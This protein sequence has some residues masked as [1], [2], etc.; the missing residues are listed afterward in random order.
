MS[1]ITSTTSSDTS[2]LSNASISMNTILAIERPAYINISGSSVLQHIIYR[3]IESND[4]DI[5]ISLEHEEFNFKEVVNYIKKLY[6]VNGD[7]CTNVIISNV[8]HGVSNAVRKY[9]SNEM[10]EADIDENVIH[11]EFDNNYLDLTS[12]ILDVNKI[13][14]SIGEDDFVDIDL[15]YIS[16]NIE[17]HLLN[18]YD[19]NVVRNYI[20]CDNVIVQINNDEDIKSDIAL[21]DFNI[22]EN[23]VFHSYT[24]KHLFK[25]VE[26]ISKYYNRGFE[27]YMKVPS[28]ILPCECEDT[29]CHC[30]TTLH[31]DLLFLTTF[32]V[33]ILAHKYN[34]LAYFPRA[35]SAK[36]YNK[37][38]ITFYKED[39]YVAP[40][41]FYEIQSDAVMTIINNFVLM[42]ELT[43]YS[44][45]PDNLYKR[46]DEVF[47][48]EVFDDDL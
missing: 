41:G 32:H 47:D 7:K 23:R 33:G 31:L 44:Y 4:I 21:Y 43:E 3:D 2:I 26:R 9:I 14:I 40:T 24:Y 12:D 38:L 39:N 1:S 37:K 36:K 15:I 29:N 10:F 8:S 5:Y 18:S 22:F 6:G 19:L 28:Q 45:R 11:N 16:T 42:K 48:Y 27:I 34:N 35:S 30:L 25:F 46:M 20:D 17:Y 13:S